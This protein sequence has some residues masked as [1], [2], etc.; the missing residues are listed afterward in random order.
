MDSKENEIELKKLKD[1]ATKTRIILKSDKEIEELTKQIACVEGKGNGPSFDIQEVRKAMEKLKYLAQDK[2]AYDYAVDS[3]TFAIH[4]NRSN[5]QGVLKLKN[6]KSAERALKDIFKS[7]G[8]SFVF[9]NML[10][11]EL[12]ISSQKDKVFSK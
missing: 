2:K 1:K 9:K 12:K 3:F 6:Q 4:Q 8:T 7:T 5:D 10:K 11:K